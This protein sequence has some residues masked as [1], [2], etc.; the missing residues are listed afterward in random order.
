MKIDPIHLKYNRFI[1][2]YRQQTDQMKAYFEY[3]PFSSFEKRL[4][5]LDKNEYQRK[6]LVEVLLE[7]NKNWGAD[8]AVH[9]N[10]K[11]LES[12]NSVV[13]IG[14]QQAGL[15]TGP[16]YSINKII[17]IIKLAKQEEEKL[18][19]PV[20]PVFWIAGEDHDF[21]E[22]NHVNIKTETGLK[23]HTVQQIPEFK[24]SI[25]EINIDSKKAG[26]WLADIY[27]E[28]NESYYSKVVYQDL[29]DMLKQ[30]KTYVDFFAKLINKLF[31]NTGLVLVDSG[32]R[33]LRKLETKYFMT[34]IENQELIAKSVFESLRSL[35]ENN[36][37][38]SLDADKDDGHLFFHDN[39]GERILL[40]K[41][42][43]DLWEGKNQEINLST[44]ELVEIAKHSPHRLSNNVVT[45]PLMQEW[46]FPTLAFVGGYGEISYWASLKGAFKEVGLEM[47][48]VVPRYSITYIPQTL[49]KILE[50]NNIN[51]TEAI[52]Q[53]V[54]HL[55]LNWLS[56]Q[57][58]AP[59]ELLV[60]EMNKSIKE[61]H[62]PLQEVAADLGED[63]KQLAETNL[64]KIYETTEFLEKRLLREINH[65]Y[66]KQI[67]EYD[68]ITSYL[69]PDNGLQERVFN[70]LLFINDNGFEIIKE[71]INLPFTFEEDH[72]LVRL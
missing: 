1:R 51:L 36:Y 72:Y 27:L 2:D 39:H 34:L 53:G 16:L 63:L 45:R 9:Q 12:K 11:R 18:K 15:L 17:S 8:T 64:N 32:N 30:S 7:M 29:L 47:P 58:N 62:L 6:E 52:N 4:D 68:L 25:S 54:N 3:N 38:I 35:H 40:K 43:S 57:T 46:L 14:G 69:Y 13:V 21:D 55:K 66:K 61:L 59:I 5:Y 33:L 20:V 23:K 31:E 41:T 10:I 22:I 48:P 42:N 67:D 71:I 44:A 19:R 49:D 50:K 24:Q 28:L 37:S 65:K 60:R 26:K 70:P 56:N